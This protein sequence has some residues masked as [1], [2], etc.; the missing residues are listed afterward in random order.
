MIERCF[1]IPKKTNGYR[2]TVSVWFGADDGTQ[3][4]LHPAL[5]V[6]TAVM[7]AHLPAIK[8]STGQF[9]L[10]PSA[11]LGFKSRLINKKPN[12]YRKTVSVWFGADDGT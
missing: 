6:I 9:D 12:G 2:K 5:L 3:Y 11:L 10:T 7:T 4:A 1:F 8:L